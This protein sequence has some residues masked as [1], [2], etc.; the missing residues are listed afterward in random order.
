MTKTRLLYTVAM[1]D[2]LFTLYLRQ[3]YG[4]QKKV[5]ALSFIEISIDS[6]GKRLENAIPKYI[7]FIGHIKD[8][9]SSFRI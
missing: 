9:D 5:S 8:V 7:H 6:A 3:K 1:T 4:I 2:S